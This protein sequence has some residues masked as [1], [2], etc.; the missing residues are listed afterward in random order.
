MI[1]SLNPFYIE[2][3]IT[4]NAKIEGSWLVKPLSIPSDSSS[5]S[6]AVIW[7][8][9]DTTSTW[10]IKQFISKYVVKNRKGEDS[11][12]YKPENYY[13]AKLIR[14]TDT[15]AYKFK[16]VLFEVNHALYADFVPANT[17]SLFK[18]R[19]TEHSFFELHTLARVTLAYNRME[20]SW[21]SAGSMK[22]MIEKKR[23]RIKYQ[24]V[25]EARRFLLTATSDD[26]TK[27]IDRYGDQTRFIDWKNQ[28][29]RLELNRLN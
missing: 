13:T 6:N 17:D 5:S 14:P 16:V 19:L 28:Q 27:M 25:N 22:E 12:W 21:L 24:W 3:N 10:T 7:G 11:A 26:L 9:A 4:L 2:R 1:G 15:V 23:V 18:S 8:I 20:L 29:A